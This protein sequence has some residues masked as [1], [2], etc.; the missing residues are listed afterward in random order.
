MQ[1]VSGILNER[2]RL[3]QHLDQRGELRLDVRVFFE[4]DNCFVNQATG[5]VIA[6]L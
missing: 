6:I 5:V 3:L 1:A 4:G 2:L